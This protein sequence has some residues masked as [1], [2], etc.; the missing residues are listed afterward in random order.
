MLNNSNNKKTGRE[1]HNI[2]TYYNKSVEK[3]HKYSIKKHE[4]KIQYNVKKKRKLRFDKTT[5]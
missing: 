4:P 2:I 1:Q 3:K 5:F